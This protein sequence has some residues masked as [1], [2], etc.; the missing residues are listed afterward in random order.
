[1]SRLIGCCVVL[2]VFLSTAYLSA[3]HR[4]SSRE[5]VVWR[6]G[7]PYADDTPDTAIP[8]ELKHRAQLQGKRLTM[9]AYP[10][11]GFAQL[12][13]NAFE[14][15][16]EPDILTFTNMGVLQGNGSVTG[17]SSSE[18]VK[19]ALV[20]AEG[21]LSA[22][23]GAQG[24]WQYL[25]RTS[26]NWEAARELAMPAPECEG[27]TQS[28]GAPEALSEQLPAMAKAYLERSSDFAQ[29]EDPEHLRSEGTRRAPIK[30]K[31]TRVCALGGNNNFAFAMLRS[32]YESADALGQISSLLIL[33][34]NGGYW[35]VLAASTDPISTGAF[36]ASLTGLISQLQKPGHD[37]APTP[38]DTA[39]LLSPGDGHA[40]TPVQ[41]ERFG[42]FVWQPAG[43]ENLVA[44]IVE[45]A[46]QNDARLFLRLNPGL[47][48]TE[49][50]SSGQLWTSKSEW[51]WRVWSINSEGKIAF[52]PT[53]RFSH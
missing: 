48:Q 31:E 42:N 26:N 30:V 33:R 23:N 7:S 51:I 19:R 38:R 45:F 28:G 12:F 36:A 27:S 21:S 46:Y 24:G 6:V 11:R 4:P 32:S 29:Y 41:D 9:K 44:E 8:P 37:H 18:P 14:A 17:I 47:Q 3:E 5:I 35:H 2:S 53:R 10:A 20:H 13:F 49:M 22:L 34:G 39:Q 16:R 50:I 40:P 1:M 25:L 15:H 43:A 52:S